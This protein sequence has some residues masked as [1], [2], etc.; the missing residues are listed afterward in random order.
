MACEYGM[1]FGYSDEVC[2]KLMVALTL[3]LCD[4]SYN[5]FG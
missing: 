1:L 4:G 5:M 3:M 2:E